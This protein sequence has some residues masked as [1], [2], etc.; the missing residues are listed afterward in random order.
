MSI[1]SHTI[2]FLNMCVFALRGSFKNTEWYCIYWVYWIIVTVFLVGYYVKKNTVFLRI[3][4]QLLIIRISLATYNFEDR[5]M[6]EDRF[7]QYCYNLGYASGFITL[8]VMMCLNERKMIHIPLSMV[9]GIFL[10]LGTIRTNAKLENMEFRE[11]LWIHIDYLVSVWLLALI[12]QYTIFGLCLYFEYLN[13]RIHNQLKL[14][15]QNFKAIVSNLDEAII[16]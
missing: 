14:C 5:Y 8:L 9:Y 11:Y 7:I 12:F 1:I 2:Y 6:Y 4:N 16:S 10:I 3:V 13:I 15:M